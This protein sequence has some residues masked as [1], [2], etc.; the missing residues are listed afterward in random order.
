MRPAF[1]PALR[2]S[3]L[4]MT[5]VLIGG[6]NVALLSFSMGLRRTPEESHPTRTHAHTHIFN[7]NSG[8][9]LG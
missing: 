8:V 5:I 9:N 6:K 4:E 2:L 7:M 1:R 3:H